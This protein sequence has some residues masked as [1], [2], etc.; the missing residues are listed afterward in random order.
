MMTLSYGRSLQ[1]AGPAYT[2]FKGCDVLACC[3]VV[4]LWPGRAQVWALLSDQFPIYWR[5]V[6]RAVRRFL[7]GYRVKRLECVVDPTSKHTK[8]WAAHLGFHF[9]C[10]MHAYGPGGDDQLMYVRLE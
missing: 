2:A 9:E 7:S 5:P 8:R 1:C 4:E 6:T 3:G 10:R